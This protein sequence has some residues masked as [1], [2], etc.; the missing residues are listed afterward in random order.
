MGWNWKGESSV[1]ILIDSPDSLLASF[2]SGTKTG[3]LILVTGPSGSGKTRWCQVLA[4]RAHE[5]GMPAIGL[6]S[7]AIFTG[8]NKVGIDLL[9]L[10][11][12][13]QRHMAVRRGESGDGHNTLDWHFDRETLDWGNNILGR[14]GSCHLLILD[15]LGP[16]EFKRGAGLTNGI[17]LISARQYQLACVVIRPSLLDD[18]EVLWPWGEIFFIPYKHPAEGCL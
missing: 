17:G 2:A 18:A 5:L 6:V 8:N 13:T 1:Q 7:P 14:L 9:N 11:C 4:E 15:E 16:L 10:A 12:G 3:Q